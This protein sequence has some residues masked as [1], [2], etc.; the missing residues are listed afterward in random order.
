MFLC[1]GQRECHEELFGSTGRDGRS[2]LAAAFTNIP[3]GK[4]KEEG[5]SK[6]RARRS[7]ALSVSCVGV[8]P[9]KAREAHMPDLEAATGLSGWEPGRASGC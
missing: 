9:S 2:L 8:A 3:G 1:T 6:P 7:T 5:G 4:I